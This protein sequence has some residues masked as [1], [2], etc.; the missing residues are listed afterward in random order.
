MTHEEWPESLFG[1]S[2]TSTAPSD[3]R[4]CLRYIYAYTISKRVRGRS[5]SN[6][7]VVISQDLG[8]WLI[9]GPSDGFTND[10]EG[11]SLECTFDLH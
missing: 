10:S 3:F 4:R 1:W 9:G 7:K 8:R 2:T 5:Q 6:A 11:F